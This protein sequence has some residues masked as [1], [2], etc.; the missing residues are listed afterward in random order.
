[1]DGMAEGRRSQ[2]HRTG[3][4]IEAGKRKG[5]LEGSSV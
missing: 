4:L 1:M 5:G 3:S 2:S